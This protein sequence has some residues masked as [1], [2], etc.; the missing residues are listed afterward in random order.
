MLGNCPAELLDEFRQAPPSG[1]GEKGQL[2]LRVAGA[3]LRLD[4]AKSLGRPAEPVGNTGWKVQIDGYQPNA[5]REDAKAAPTNPAVDFTLITPNGHKA[6]YSLLGRLPAKLFPQDGA[7]HQANAA[8]A[9]QVWYHVPDQRFG[10]E[11]LRSALQFV[12]APAGKLCYR[13]FSSQSGEFSLEQQG[14]ATRDETYP[15]WS[16]TA[17]W[18][19]TVQEYLPQAV[20][21]PWYIPEDRRAGLEDATGR[22]RPAIRCRLYAAGKDREFW[23]GRSPGNSTRLTVGGR[24]FAVGFNDKASDLGFQVK[25]LR[26]ETLVDPGSNQNAAYTSW[27]ELTDKARHVEAEDRIITMNQ[28]LQYQGYKFFQSGLESAGVDR[29]TLKPISYSIFTVSRD[30]GLWLKYAGSTMLAM[31]IACMFYMKAYFFKPRGRRPRADLATASGG[32]EGV[33]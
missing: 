15:V 32:G 19:F 13:A 8:D 2:F 12:A 9:L 33:S 28:P 20:N 21:E 4:V 17:G 31:G 30:P 14:V 10:Q 11:S 27:V 29:A 18:K 1:L 24:E 16:K 5:P 22:L 7:G 26:A 3:T 23:V 6:A 25:L